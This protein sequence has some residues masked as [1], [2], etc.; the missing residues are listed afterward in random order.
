MEDLGHRR[1]V[2]RKRFLSMF[3]RGLNPVVKGSGISEKAFINPLRFFCRNIRI[4]KASTEVAMTFSACMTTIPV[5]DS[6]RLGNVR[7]STTRIRDV[8]LK[9]PPEAYNFILPSNSWSFL[10]L[11]LIDTNFVGVHDLQSST[12]SAVCCHKF[13]HILSDQRLFPVLC[14]NY[15]NKILVHFIFV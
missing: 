8:I 4:M 13:G 7:R 6:A 1:G 5:I 14:S 12:S 15:H 11:P 3:A 2:R 10:E 9:I